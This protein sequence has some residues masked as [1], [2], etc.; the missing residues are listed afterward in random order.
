VIHQFGELLAFSRAARG[1]ADVDA[2]RALF[3]GC[4]RVATATD[5][6]DR[7]GVD[8]VVEL[9]GG[10][11]VYVDA[12]ARRAGC[13]RF[14]GDGPELALE[15]W[16]VMPGPGVDGKVGWTLNES[17]NVD[18][19]LFTFDPADCGEAYLFAFQLLRLAFR[20]HFPQWRRAYREDVQDSGGWR[21]MAVYVPL[22]AVQE[23][24]AEVSRLQLEAA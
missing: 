24:V 10:A 16:S 13:S 3:P 8:Y 1:R 19:I 18:Y 15:V 22:A 20:G 12:K 23:A 4:V 9:R 5:E 7:A 17:T 6:M 21:S 11:Q 14:W 2:L